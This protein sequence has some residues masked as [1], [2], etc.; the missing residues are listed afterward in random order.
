MKRLA[1]IFLVLS[2]TLWVTAGT[3]SWPSGRTARGMVFEDLN[4]NGVWDADEPG[5]PNVAV[6]NQR[7]VVRTDSLGRYELPVDDQTIL[8]VTK[9][10]GY[11]TPVNEFNLPQFYYI[12]QPNGSPPGLQYAGIEPTGPLP[13]RVDFPLLKTEV[14]RRFR[15]IVSGDPQPRDLKEV[16]YLRDDVYADMLAHEADLYLALGDIMFDHLD[17]YHPLN[18]VV[19]QL[20]VPVYNVPGNHDMNY[21]VG[22]DRFAHETFK[23]VF[24]PEYYSFEYGQVH[25]VVLEDVLYAG[26]DATLNQRGA[27]KGFL[28]EKQLQWLQNDLALVPEDFLVVLTMHIP[29]ASALREDSTHVI[30]NRARLFEILQDRRHLLALAGHYHTIEHVALDSS[31]G[32]Q[33]ETRFPLLIAGAACGAWWSGPKDER[34]IPATLGLDGSPNGY[35]VFEFEDQNFTYRF[36]PASQSPDYQLR[37]S[38]PAGRITLEQAQKEPVLVNVFSSPPGTTVQY[39]LDDGAPIPM[40][41]TVA[42][43]P[44][45]EAYLARYRK[46]ESGSGPSARPTNHLWGAPLPDGLEPGV[47]TIEAIAT[48]PFGNTFTAYTIFEIS[49]TAPQANSQ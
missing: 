26:W 40:K 19:A 34:G 4:R 23:R 15:A 31:K 6:S 13:E 29:I 27:Y 11:Q 17:L 2:W 36:Y 28:T 44:F 8:F 14:K 37:V 46:Q 42:T 45:V 5:V 30:G 22:D 16:H 7:E 3:A 41:P 25:F 12:H 18:A 32:W 21:R 38:A 35:F 33:S 47:H 39:V 9:P 20:G 1:L 43:D 48:D 10:P 24:G 49:E